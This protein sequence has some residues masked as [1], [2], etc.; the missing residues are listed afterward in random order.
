MCV[1]RF[2][3]VKARSSAGRQRFREQSSRA[4]QTR[5]TAFATQIER[6]LREY[7]LQVYNSERRRLL[8]GKMPVKLKKRLT[9][10]ELETQLQDLM[11]RFGVAQM[12]DAGGRASAGSFSVTPQLLA[13]IAQEKQ[14]KVKLLIDGTD[15]KIRQSLKDIFTQASREV[16]KPTQAEI[17]RRIARS[18]FGPTTRENPGRATRAENRMTADW[19][20]VGDFG[21]PGTRP[22]EQEH[23][24]SFTRAATIARTELAQIESNGIIKGLIAAGFT[25]VAW[26][27][28]VNDGRSAT[29]MHYKM[30]KHPPIP[31]EAIVNK[32]K[33]QWFQLP[34]GIFAPYP[35]WIGLPAGETVNCR[36]FPTG[37]D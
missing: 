36:C 10:K 17:G 34:S 32:V 30:N 31:I 15:S 4:V 37:A 6:L 23:L 22:G 2:E 24:F 8:R 11:T 1:A 9:R 13:E 33:A 35:N 21:Q 7:G 5:S 3:I 19:R 29:R 20:R 25:K 28:R 18:W 14:Q 12:N 16:P 26:T 27:A